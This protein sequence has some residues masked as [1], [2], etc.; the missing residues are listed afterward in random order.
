MAISISRRNVRRT[1]RVRGLSRGD[2][3]TVYPKTGT[4]FDD[5]VT[6]IMGVAFDR[7]CKE[8]HDRGQPEIVLEVIAQR[9]IEAAKNGERDPD[10]LRK[11]GLSALGSDN[12]KE[13]S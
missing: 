4:V 6:R 5:S 13:A 9:I 10:R 7:A 1:A 2:H 8:L 3:F 12:D 11:I